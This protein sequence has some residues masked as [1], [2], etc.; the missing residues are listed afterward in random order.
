MYTLRAHILDMF[1]CNH[2]FART[3]TGSFWQNWLYIIFDSGK[4]K[5]V[6]ADYSCLRA[7]VLSAE[8]VFRC[9]VNREKLCS[10]A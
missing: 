7:V 9:H 2:L 3:A 1:I 8:L 10:Y 4:F 6:K 5:N